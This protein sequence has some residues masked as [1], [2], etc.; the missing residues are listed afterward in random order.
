VQLHARQSKAFPAARNRE[1]APKRYFTIKTNTE[2][3]ALRVTAIVENNRAEL[4]E[5]RC[6]T[7]TQMRIEIPGTKISRLARRLQCAR[8]KR[9]NAM[10][11]SYHH[12]VRLAGACF[13]QSQQ[14]R[15][16]VAMR[17]VVISVWNKKTGTGNQN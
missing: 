14:R 6:P 1:L 5:G 10:T 3:R 12:H 15:A 7:R 11:A 4:P 17:P 2:V 13:T 16:L 8:C 9:F